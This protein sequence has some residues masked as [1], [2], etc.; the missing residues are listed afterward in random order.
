MSGLALPS[1]PQWN[2]TNS[3]SGSD[4]R[5]DAG[6]GTPPLPRRVRSRTSSPASTSMRRASARVHLD[7]RLRVRPRPARRPAGSGCRTGNACSNRPVVRYVRVVGVGHLGRRRAARRRWKRARPSVV[8]KRSANSRGVPG[9]LGRA[10]PE[11]ALLGVDAL[12]GDAGV[13]GDAARAGAAQLVEHLRGSSE[14][15]CPL[16]SRSARRPSPRRSVANAGRR[17]EGAPA[18]G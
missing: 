9:W 17:R 7:A 14:K 18:R 6:R 11:H 12:V 13:V 1:P 2:G 10:R 4:A 5:H 8:G 3:V 16:P 15:R